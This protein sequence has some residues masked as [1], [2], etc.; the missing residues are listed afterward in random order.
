MN[1][2]RRKIIPI[3]ISAS[4]SI[5]CPPNISKFLIYFLLYAFITLF[6]FDNINLFLMHIDHH[7][8][9]NVI[10][11]SLNYTHICKLTDLHTLLFP[12]EP[13]HIVRQIQVLT[14]KYSI[15][16]FYPTFKYRTIHNVFHW[17]QK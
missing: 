5:F 3:K 6:S 7:N 11:H 15:Y 16:C 14:Y 1:A 17:N 4:K 8:S 10:P 9:G 2:H 12:I 13:I